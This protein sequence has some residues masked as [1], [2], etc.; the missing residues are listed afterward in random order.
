MALVI[1][2]HIEIKAVISIRKF[3]DESKKMVDGKNL[4][5]ITNKSVTIKQEQTPKMDKLIAKLFPSHLKGQARWK[6][7]LKPTKKSIVSPKFKQLTSPP[8]IL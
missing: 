5:H 1:S 3:L 8:N 7:K 2:K 6:T 4:N